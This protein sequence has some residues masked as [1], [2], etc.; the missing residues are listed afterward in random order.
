M[1]IDMMDILLHPWWGRSGPRRS[2][3]SISQRHTSCVQ[4]TAPQLGVWSRVEGNS[5]SFT[6]LQIW[7]SVG[8]M[9]ST[10]KF[11]TL[12]S[13]NS[14]LYHYPLS[15][16]LAFQ[17]GG[18]LGYYQHSA[19]DSQLSILRSKVSFTSLVKLSSKNISIHCSFYFH[20][21]QEIGKKMNHQLKFSKLLE[22]IL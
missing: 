19:S 20:L 1:S 21:V 18:V 5:Q 3:C 11:Q 16:P 14:K 4:W 17:A 12:Q 9:V 13:T 22:F 2:L 10:I 6:E 8:G 15:S 7:R